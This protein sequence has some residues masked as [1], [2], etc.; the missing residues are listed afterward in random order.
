MLVGVEAE[1]LLDAVVALVCDSTGPGTLPLRAGIAT[2]P[3]VVFE[4]DD[5]VGKAINL[6][7]RLSDVAGPDEILVASAGL[8]PAPGGVTSL[9][10]IAGFREPVAVTSI[11][12]LLVAS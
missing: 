5:Y 10:S 12:P 11:R 7:A 9:R 1:P 2:G 6:A 3:V 4:G 8:V